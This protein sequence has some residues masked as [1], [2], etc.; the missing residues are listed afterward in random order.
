MAVDHAIGGAAVFAASSAG[1]IAAGAAGPLNFSLS[2]FGAIS[3][4]A[5]MG[6]LARVFLDA[7]EARDKARASGVEPEH[8]P[9]VDVIALGY[10]LLGAPLMGSIGLAL[11]HLLGFLPDYA[12]VPVI[13]GMG[14]LGRDGIN[15]AISL[16]Q[17]FVGQ[18]AAGGEG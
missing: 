14:Y 1:L 7:K 16:F 9:R 18:K 8:Y 5:A 2:Q 6:A 10:A 17:R 12:A 4:L 15:W 3:L 13:M 11:V